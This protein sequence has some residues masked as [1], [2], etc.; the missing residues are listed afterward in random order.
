MATSVLRAVATPPRLESAA[1]KWRSSGLTDEQAE[2]LG[3]TGLTG[4]ET[5]ALNPR[6]HPVEALQIP[7]LDWDGRR[8][9]FYRLRYLAPLPGFAGQAERPQRYAQS[10]GSINEIY[11]PNLC[12]R[13]WSEIKSDPRVRLLVTEG[14]LKAAAICAAGLYGLGLGGVD[15]W[16]SS[17]RLLPI[18][19]QLGEID[20]R[21]REVVIV[22]DSD[23]AEK[24]AVSEAQRRLA[25]ELLAR[26]A[27]LSIVAL[28]PADDGG[29]QG[30]DDYLVT[31]GGDALLALVDGAP[32]F[33][34]SD[35]LH[36]LNEEI[37]LVRNPGI[38]I[39]VA[40]G[41]QMRPA[42]AVNVQFANRRYWMPDAKGKLV[43]KSLPE[44]WIRWEH[45][46]EAPRIVYAPGQPQRIK[47][48]GEWNVWTG[49]GC[50][51]EPGDITP[52]ATLL[53]YIFRGEPELRAWFER[54]CAYPIKFPG[55]KLYTAAVLWSAATG[56]GK[57]LVAYTLKRI[58]GDNFSEAKS[59]DLQAGFNSWQRHRQFVYGDEINAAD[60]HKNQDHLKGLI[61]QE[62][63]RIEEKFV[64]SYTIK[65]CINYLLASNHPDCVKVDPFDRRYMVQEIVGGPL[66]PEFYLD[67]YDPW[68]KGSGPSHLFHHLLHLP[69]GDFNPRGRAPM[70]RAKAEM[71]QASTSDIVRWVMVLLADPPSVLHPL[72]PGMAGCDLFTADQ[73][74]RCYDPE[75]RR[76]VTV[77][78]MARALAGQQVRVVANGQQVRTSHGKVR[79]YPV[80]NK[81]RWSVANSARCVAHF[82]QHFPPLPEKK[83]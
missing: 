35:A 15:V 82:N 63:I 10:R 64:P 55:T 45:R 67:V 53:D 9:G 21:E 38:V 22:F 4:E 58:Y 2:T 14:E 61:T 66:E 12:D 3:L 32:P 81:T 74:L 26:G 47:G 70:S 41:H 72:G 37:V 57:T 18:L 11:L 42:D 39:E 83:F 20:W 24:P 29:R 49:W 28:P 68:L 50:E 1:L 5:H 25:R 77:G 19:P 34:E 65:D 31:H 73:L 76:G 46:H 16:R 7:Y 75:G 56:T 78:G 6:F 52:W 43:E 71:T 40:S 13:P 30:A 8:T 54:W 48:T 27:R 69:M 59:C 23:A 80:R 62:E 36:G 60:S 44:R 51:P 33:T 79:L 17:R